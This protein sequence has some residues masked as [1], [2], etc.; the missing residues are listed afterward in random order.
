MVSQYQ[1]SYSVQKWGHAN[2]WLA[3]AKRLAFAFSSV[4]S[5]MHKYNWGTIQL[6][7]TAKVLK[8]KFCL[9]LFSWK[10][11]W[12]LSWFCPVLAGFGRFWPPVWCFSNLSIFCIFY[13]IYIIVECYCTCILREFKRIFH[14]AKFDNFKDEKISDFKIVSVSQRK[15]LLDWKLVV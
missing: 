9:R 6:K 15:N 14:P 1:N 13:R 11:I 2:G 10:I 3:A 4:S 7:A 12:Y 8:K 5:S